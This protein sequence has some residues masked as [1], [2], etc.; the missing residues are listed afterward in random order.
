MKADTVWLA[1]NEKTRTDYV[2]TVQ[3]TAMELSDNYF[4]FQ[5][6]FTDIM[7]GFTVER[8]GRREMGYKN[9]YQNSI[10]FEMSL[11]QIFYSRNVYNLLQV[12]TD[13]GGI[14]SAIRTLFL[15][16][17]IICNTFSS[18]QFVMTDLFVDSSLTVSQQ[19]SKSF[20]HRIDPKNDVQWNLCRQMKTTLQ[21]FCPARF[22]CRCLRLSR[23][24][25]LRSKALKRVMTEVR[26]DNILKELRVLRA[27]AK[28]IKTK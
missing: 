24:Q 20:T 11:K 5:N 26:I 17:M 12:V 10:T 6:F 8:S 27:A 15:A 2:F 1:L 21:T 22:L 14:V 13:L 23:K 7:E 18:Y 4:S 9:R 19:G 25:R 3:R 28:S 16:I